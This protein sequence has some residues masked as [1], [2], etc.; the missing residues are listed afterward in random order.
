M[1]AGGIEPPSRDVF[2]RASTCV[3]GHLSFAVNVSGLQDTSK[4]RLTISHPTCVN[5][6]S[7]ASPL[8]SL[9]STSGR[10]GMNG[11]PYLG[12]HAQLRVGI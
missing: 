4:A 12:G 2:Q 6:P 1:E 9:I 8:T 7:Q 10:R 11:S 5:Q 3:V